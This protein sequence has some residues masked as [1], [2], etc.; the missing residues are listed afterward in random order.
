MTTSRT[1]LPVTR[2]EP[3]MSETSMAAGFVGSVSGTTSRSASSGVPVAAVSVTTA[4]KVAI[5]YGRIFIVLPFPSASRPQP[6]SR[7]VMSPLTVS[8][9]SATPP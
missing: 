8:Q 4:A 7:I 5:A 3:E 2:I 6:R 9:S 1:A